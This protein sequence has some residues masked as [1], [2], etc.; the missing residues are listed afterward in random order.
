[1]CSFPLTKLQKGYNF[2]FSCLKSLFFLQIQ[3]FST[4]EKTRT[5]NL[6]IRSQMLYPIELRVQ[7]RCALATSFIKNV[8]VATF[9]TPEGS[10]TPNPQFRRL[11]LYPVELPVRRASRSVYGIRTRDLR[12]ERAA[13]WAARRTRRKG[14]KYTLRQP[15][16]KHSARE[17]F[18][19]GSVFFSAVLLRLLGFPPMRLPK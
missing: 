11:M 19:T 18:T 16:G 10:R 12:L 8:G 4:P 3:R 5:S 2:R 15:F 6:L 13:S 14:R 1:M 7:M 9:G 17:F